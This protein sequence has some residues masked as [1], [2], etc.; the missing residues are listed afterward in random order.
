M[1]TNRNW[2]CVSK[3]AEAASVSFPEFFGTFDKSPAN[4]CPSVCIR[5]H[6]WLIPPSL[7]GHRWTRMH[8]DTDAH[9]SELDLCF[10]GAGAAS[11]SFPVFF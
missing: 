6:P 4:L 11:V 1:H 7:N 9:E 3:G 10:K 8:T 2:I 5:V